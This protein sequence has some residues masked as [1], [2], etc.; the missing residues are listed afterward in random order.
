SHY[1]W[2]LLG[3]FHRF[4]TPVLDSAMLF[5]T[6][7]GSVKFYIVVFPVTLSVLARWKRWRELAGM[8]GAF[9]GALAL[10]ELLKHSFHRIRPNLYLIK[11]TGYSFPS[12]HAM[13]SLVFYGMLIYFVFCHAHFRR[14]RSILLAL[15]VFLTLAIGFSRIYLGVHYPSD[16]LGS[17]LAGFLWLVITIT[18]MKLFTRV[19]Y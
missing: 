10:N 3:Y 15:A 14:W 12:G 2:F 7:L 8:C 17:Y 6:F 16:V 11:E 1:Y 5:F 4:S 19:Y 18:A 9:G 13:I